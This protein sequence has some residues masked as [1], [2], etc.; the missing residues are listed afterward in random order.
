MILAAPSPSRELLGDTFELVRTG[1]QLVRDWYT[2]ARCPPPSRRAAERPVLEQR[3]T[4]GFNPG[5]PER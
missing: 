1:M 2:Y 3:I 5:F 4:F